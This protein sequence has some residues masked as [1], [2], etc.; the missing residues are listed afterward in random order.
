[1]TPLPSSS[2][3]LLKSNSMMGLPWLAG[4]IRLRASWVEGRKLKL[5]ARFESSLSRFSFNRLEK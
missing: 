4:A 5:N 1:M 2:I 3:A